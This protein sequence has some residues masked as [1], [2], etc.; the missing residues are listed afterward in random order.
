MKSRVSIHIIFRILYHIVADV[1]IV[2]EKKRQQK[3]K[4][5]HVR[6]THARDTSSSIICNSA[7]SIRASHAKA[8]SANR[9]GHRTEKKGIHKS[10][11]KCYYW[12]RM[13][14]GIL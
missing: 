13:T 11:S 1:L 6:R 5:V 9:F 3:C 8:I 2:I 10:T 4:H 14:C 12:T 7:K